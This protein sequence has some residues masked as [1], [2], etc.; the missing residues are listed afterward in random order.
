VSKQR[1]SDRVA[2]SG[3]QA[4]L[5]SDGDAVR[6]WLRRVFHNT[7]S[8]AVPTRAAAA[9]E[10]RAIHDVGASEDW[11]TV[12]QQHSGRQRHTFPK[13]DAVWL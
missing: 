2:A 3:L 9:A 4:A 13:T 8:L 7:F 11:E 12:I 10:A 1:P 6:F 5:L